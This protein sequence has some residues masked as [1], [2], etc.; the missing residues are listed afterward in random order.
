MS[1]QR[2]NE[3]VASS[4][5][6]DPSKGGRARAQ[7]LTPE[8]RQDIA[9]KAAESRWGTGLPQA[10]HGSDDH[11]LRIGEIEIPCY[12]LEDGR[13]VLAQKGMIAGLNMSQG[14]AG[15]GS[16]DRLV[17][18]VQG[19]SINPFVPKD[20]HDLITNPIRFRTP[21]G[22]AV[23]YGYEA[24]A[25]ADLCD[26][27]LEA[28]KQGKL[29]HQ[30]EHIAQRCEILVRGFARV[31]IIALVDEATGY[32]YYRR[33]RALEE[34]LEQFISKELLKWAKIFPDEFYQEMFRLKR[35]EYRQLSSKRP[36]QAGRLTND[37]V[38]ERLAPGVLD[39]LKRITPRNDK[40]RPKHRYHQRLT[41]DVGHPRLREHLSAV[42]ALMR[43]FDD[44][45]SFYRSLNRALPK[46]EKMPL[47][48]W[49]ESQS[50]IER[51]EPAEAAENQDGD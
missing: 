28:R 34:I 10:T 20:L 13:R 36:I 41:E 38:Y 39:E 42:I 32:Q 51:E 25:L 3:G 30:Q 23:A 43:A 48:E 26:A 9:R 45:T 49:A 37:L 7:V 19:K 12:V 15:G 2:Q 47:I 14:T 6:L 40:G 35:W 33:R 16:G 4:G 21:D 8:E 11:P 31:G 46:Q 22:K 27:V 17:N 44:W 5:R 24:T 18:F 29:N 1:D 50:A